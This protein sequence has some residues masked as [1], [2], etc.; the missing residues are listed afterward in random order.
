MKEENIPGLTHS[1][2]QQLLSLFHN[3][4]TI[5]VVTLYGSRAKGNFKVG[6]DIDLSIE[7]R[8]LTTSW[9][10]DFSLQVDDLL[11]PYEFD[12]VIFKHIDNLDLKEHINRV[13][14]IIYKKD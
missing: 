4:E 10:L 14:K 7:G 8:E 5:E 13:G 9:L 11:L 6:S 3:H 2:N 12:L 1:Q